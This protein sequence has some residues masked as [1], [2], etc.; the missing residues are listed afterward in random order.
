ML[1]QFDWFFFLYIS[2]GNFCWRILLLSDLKIK[3]KT[4][5]C[6]LGEYF[7][8]LFRA[9][10][11][12]NACFRMYSKTCWPHNSC[13][14]FTFHFGAAYSLRYWMN[15]EHIRSHTFGR[16][17]LWDYSVWMATN[18]AINNNNKIE[19]ELSPSICSSN[20]NEWTTKLVCTEYVILRFWSTESTPLNILV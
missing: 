19:L 5:Y 7:T 14:V 4:Y 12:E 11:T 13:L 20:R 2:F 16:R 15:I 3:I 8:V 6:S 18:M 10:T 9:N 17:A 1:I